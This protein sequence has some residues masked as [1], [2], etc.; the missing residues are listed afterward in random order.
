ME[1]EHL[2]EVACECL[3]LEN[4]IPDL[5][6]WENMVNASKNPTKEVNIAL[7]GKYI[8]LHDAYIS[9]V[10]SLKHAGIA[11]SATVNI[12]WVD[13]ETVTPENVKGI[14]SDV[15]GILV[16]VD[17]VTEV[18]KVKFLRFSTLV[19]IRFRSLDFVLVCSFL[20]WN[21]QD[22]LLATQM[23]IALN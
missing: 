19:K 20:S 10:E 12:K 2:A 21:L 7:V 22:M 5:K 3:K 4:R 9:V 13:S 11:N 15:S 8:S 14:L 17:L 6:E 23:L 18:L 1:K 16:P